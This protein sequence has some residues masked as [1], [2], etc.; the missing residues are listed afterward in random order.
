MT[1]LASNWRVRE[2]YNEVN[3]LTITV[4]YHDDGLSLLL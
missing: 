2:R 4:L 1:D 3:E